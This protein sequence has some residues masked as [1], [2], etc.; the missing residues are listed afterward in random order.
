MDTQKNKH[1]RAMGRKRW[2]NVSKE[3]RRKHM[4]ALSLLA[5]A[6]RAKEKLQR[7]ENNS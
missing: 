2:A 3:D 4:T 6:K 5:A 7:A 1:A